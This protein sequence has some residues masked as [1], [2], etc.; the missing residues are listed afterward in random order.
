MHTKLIAKL[1]LVTSLALSCGLLLT[2]C[3]GD[4][5]ADAAESEIEVQLPPEVGEAAKTIK[6]EAQEAAEAVTD[7]NADDELEALEKT[8]DGDGE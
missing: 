3:P 4:A 8:L 2:S 1:P 5:E 6:A 7:E